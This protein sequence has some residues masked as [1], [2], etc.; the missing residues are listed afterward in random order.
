MTTSKHPVTR[1]ELAHLMGIHTKT[2]YRW[3]KQ[4]EIILKNRL[5]SPKERMMILKRFGYHHEKELEK[6][7]SS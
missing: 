5:I 1:K 2:L 4:E 6:L 3:L 7:K